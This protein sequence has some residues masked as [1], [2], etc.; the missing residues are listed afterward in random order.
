[1]ASNFPNS[2][3]VGQ[4]FT[5]NGVTRQWDGTAWISVATTVAGPQGSQGPAGP[6]SVAASVTYAYD[7]ASLSGI[8]SSS[9]ALQSYANSGSLIAY[10]SASTYT[11]TS[12]YNNTNASAGYSLNSASLGGV[13]ALDYATD[14]DVYT[15]QLTPTTS[16]DIFPRTSITG[17]R[18]LAAGSIYSTGFVP[19]KSF[20]L[21][22]VTIVL[23]GGTTSSIQFGLFSTSGSIITVLASTSSAVPSGAGSF[24][25]SFSTP[26]TLTAG[27]SYAIGFLA[28]GGTNPILVGQTFSTSNA[29]I[30]YGL[31]PLMTAISS[32]TTY[33]SIPAAGNTI[34]TNVATPPVSMAWARLS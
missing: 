32:T 7:S 20:T 28:V 18:T 31:S 30:S 11:S 9:Y 4:Q 16:I 25:A 27:Q 33:S 1:M 21:N 34:A 26:Q 10:N 23:T 8:V 6:T 5:V 15:T 13:R 22:S 24:T 19:I 3:S 17:T 12:A 14:T 2:A 29:A